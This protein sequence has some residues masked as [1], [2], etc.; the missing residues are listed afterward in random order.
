MGFRFRV[1]NGIDDPGGGQERVPPLVHGRRARVVPESI[2]AD[3]PPLDAHD[4]LDDADVDAA[5]VKDRALL[6]VEL[7]KGEDLAQLPVFP[8]SSFAKVTTSSGWR[9]SIPLSRRH[10]TTSIAPTEPTCPS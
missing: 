10:W 1:P 2:D 7:E 4:S 6:D 3:V 8:F 9:V 5:A